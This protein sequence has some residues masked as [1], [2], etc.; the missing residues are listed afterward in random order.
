MMRPNNGFNT[1]VSQISQNNLLILGA[2][3]HGIFSETM[4]DLL[5]QELIQM[6]VL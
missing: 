6:G 3:L 2:L 4:Y 1:D 5:K